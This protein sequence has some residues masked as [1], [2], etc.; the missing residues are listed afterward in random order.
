[1]LSTVGH[2]G[3][4]CAVAILARVSRHCTTVRMLPPAFSFDLHGSHLARGAWRLQQ[5]QGRLFGG[6]ST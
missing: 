6:G 3:L 4:C 2:E 1:M 5:G